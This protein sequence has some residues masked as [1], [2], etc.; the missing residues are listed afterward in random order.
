MPPLAMIMPDSTNMGTA[1]RGK[2]SRPLNMERMRN[3]AL[4]VKEGSNTTGS[5]DAM[6][7]EMDTGM[8]M[9][10]QM[11]KIKNSSATIYPSSLSV[12]L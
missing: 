8:A 5:A 2:E 4:T 6:P 7:R 12:C 9:T 3:L 1:S 10:R 11:I